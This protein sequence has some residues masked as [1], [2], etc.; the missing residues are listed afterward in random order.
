MCTIALLTAPGGH[1]I[2]AGNRDELRTR[3]PSYPPSPHRLDAEALLAIYPVDANALGTWIGFNTAGLAMTLLNNYQASAIFDTRGHTP[4]SRGRIIPEL[5]ARCSALRQVEPHIRTHF[6]DSLAHTFP[7]ILIAAHRDEHPHALRIEWNGQDLLC[8]TITA[9]YL[10]ISSGFDLPG[11]RTARQEAL[12]PLLEIEDWTTHPILSEHPDAVTDYFQ[13]PH[14]HAYT[15]TMSREDAHTVSHT[16][17]IL[18]PDESW[19]THIQG[20][21]HRHRE[22]ISSTLRVPALP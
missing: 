10:E 17:I 9:P 22:V 14:P 13:S 2:L 20:P 1:L 6:S 3:H 11:V 16:R 4:S 7:F 21:P 12:A 8:D 18:A 5:L 15:V 19:L